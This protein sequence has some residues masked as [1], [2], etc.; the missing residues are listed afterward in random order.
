[1]T[2]VSG[3]YACFNFQELSLK[4]NSK[5]SLVFGFYPF[6]LCRLETG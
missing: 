4:C 2:D 1:M 6:T 3:V 5:R